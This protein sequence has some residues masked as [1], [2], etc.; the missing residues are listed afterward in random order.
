MH[1]VKCLI[2][3]QIFVPL[4]MSSKTYMINTKENNKKTLH[5]TEKYRDYSDDDHHVNAED[6]DWNEI[7]DDWLDEDEYP[8]G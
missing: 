3:L 8:S 1:I 2:L 7:D 4:I 6:H 5:Q